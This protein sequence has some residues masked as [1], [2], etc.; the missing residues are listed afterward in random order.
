MILKLILLWLCQNLWIKNLIFLLEIFTYTNGWI[1]P[2]TRTL[3]SHLCHQPPGDC[4]FI[5][6]WTR[7]CGPSLYPQLLCLLILLLHGI[8]QSLLENHSGHLLACFY[9]QTINHCWENTI[10]LCQSKAPPCKLSLVILLRVLTSTARLRFCWPGLLAHLPALTPP[11]PA[12]PSR[13]FPVGN[14]FS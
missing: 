5:P 1:S 14:V 13:P 12:Q 4:I 6:V 10:C 3:A 9:M 2:D 7:P 8:C 11:A